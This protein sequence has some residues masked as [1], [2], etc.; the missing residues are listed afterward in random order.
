MDDYCALHKFDRRKYPHTVECDEYDIAFPE[1][2]A[3]IIEDKVKVEEIRKKAF[4][5]YRPKLYPEH[6][7]IFT[8]IFTAISVLIIKS[9]N[10]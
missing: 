2:L 9:F 5:E 7:M 3:D 8:L 6:I 4:H 1:I 10:M